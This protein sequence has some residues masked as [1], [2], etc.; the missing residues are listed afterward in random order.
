M[1]D[2]TKPK[3]SKFRHESTSGQ[4]DPK[5]SRDEKR[6]KKSKFR[7]EKTEKKLDKATQKLAKK[8]PRKPHPVRDVVMGALGNE[9]RQRIHGKIHEVERENV[10]TE[11]AH[12]AEL[13]AERGFRTTSRFV[14]N[15]IRTSPVRKVRKRQRKHIKAKADYNFRQMAQENPALK[16]NVFKRHLQKRKL[17]RQYQKQTKAYI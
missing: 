7:V 9:V 11:A 14:K 5:L 13:T 17:R 15:R 10:G 2:D 3:S 4:V 8:K 12:R 1:R 16:K 6:L